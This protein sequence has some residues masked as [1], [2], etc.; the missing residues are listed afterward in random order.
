MKYIFFWIAF[1]VVLF[2]MLPIGISGIFFKGN[3]VISNG[4]LPREICLLN[5]KTGKKENMEFEKYI[6]GVVMAEM[7]ATFD[8]EALKAQSV[9]ARTYALSK[10]KSE[11]GISTHHGA[12]VCDDFAHCQAYVTM[13]KAMSN[14]G[15]N[16]SEC[17]EK[18]KNAVRDTEG[19]VMLYDGEPI[20]AVFHS[21]SSGKTE[22]AR[23]VWGGNVDYLVSV[24]SPGERECPSHESEVSVEIKAFKEKVKKEYKADFSKEIIG[25]VMYNESGSV[26]S[27][28]VGTVKI[29]GTEIRKMF[30][31]R[32]AC[33]KAEVTDDM[34]IFKVVGNGHGV[35]M[36]QYGA[37][38][39]AK[40][41]YDYMQILK[42]YYNGVEIEKIS[43]KNE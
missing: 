7:P 28:S 14:W 31:L 24:E 26:K 8:S 2:I 37:N 9:A 38:Y 6:L 22:N 5:T 34:V 32:S 35:G 36:S 23:D 27:L 17:L 42:R 33:F 13:K 41:G 16:A 11:R 30:N 21:S 12:D 25:E 29:K 15:K 18:C 40:S 3:E 43:S 1:L 4:D 20:K 10:M 39:L 19:E